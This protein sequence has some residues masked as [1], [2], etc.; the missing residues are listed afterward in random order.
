M[1]KKARRAMFNDMSPIKNIKCHTPAGTICEEAKSQRGSLLANKEIASV[2][3]TCLCG[4][5]KGERSLA[6]TYLQGGPQ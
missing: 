3:D 2:A 6:M 5:C 1:Q 4:R